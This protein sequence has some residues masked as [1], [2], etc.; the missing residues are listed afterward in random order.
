MLKN[1]LVNKGVI[2]RVAEALGD[3]DG[4]AESR[5]VCSERIRGIISAFV[6]PTRE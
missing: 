3:H 5:E 1:T 6:D 4:K 2:K